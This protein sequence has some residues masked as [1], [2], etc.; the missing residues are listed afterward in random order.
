VKDSIARFI[1]TGAYTGYAPVVPGTFGTL[2][3]IALSPLFASLCARSPVLYVLALFAAIVVAIW[4]AGVVVQQEQLSD[5]QIVV[6]DEVV[7]Y[8]LAVA[9]LPHLTVGVTVAAF[10]AFRVFDI[11]KPFPGRRLEHLPG[12]LGVVADDLWAG[13]LAF[14]VVRGL[15]VAHVI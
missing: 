15:M 6:V 3:G 14:A 8:L 5:P 13:I 12:G 2:P 11:I 4:A 1:G 10:L 7:G 9:F